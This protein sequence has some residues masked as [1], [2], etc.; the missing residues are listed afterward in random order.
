MIMTVE[1]KAILLDIYEDLAKE[2]GWPWA[3]N[4]SWSRQIME[5]REGV[6]YYIPD[7]VEELGKDHPKFPLIAHLFNSSAQEPEGSA[8]CHNRQDWWMAF[9]KMLDDTKLYLAEKDRK[10]L[11][12]DLSDLI[13]H[14]L[15]RQEY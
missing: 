4:A 7:G 9:V 6:P 1:E 3:K 13:G 8:D 14:R 2:H 11:Y 10:E 5:D 12:Q 15:N